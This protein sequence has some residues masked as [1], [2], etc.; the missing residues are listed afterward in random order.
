[1]TA[2]VYLPSSRIGACRHDLPLR[3]SSPLLAVILA[4]EDH[5][6]ALR[7]LVKQ[8]MHVCLCLFRARVLYI[9]SSGS[10]REARHRL[11]PRLTC[12]CLHSATTSD[13]SSTSTSASLVPGGPSPTPRSPPSSSACRL[14]QSTSARVQFCQVK[15]FLFTLLKFRYQTLIN[16]NQWPSWFIPSKLA[17][18]P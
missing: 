1:L 12:P 11:L 16:S 4:T 7:V 8:R 14:Y 18:D 2:F 13:S 6:R 10:A 17:G 15:K 5:P 9:A 3:A